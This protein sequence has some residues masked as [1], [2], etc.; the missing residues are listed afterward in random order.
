MYIIIVEN[1]ILLT[2][3]R[4][5]IMIIRLMSIH[6]LIQS[7][8]IEFSLFIQ[9]IRTKVNT[10]QSG[11]I[12]VK[13]NY[14]FTFSCSVQ[15]QITRTEC[16]YTL[17]QYLCSLSKTVKPKVIEKLTE[18]S[19]FPEEENMFDMQSSGNTHPFMV[20]NRGK[21]NKNEI[22]NKELQRIL[23]VKSMPFCLKLEESACYVL[24]ICQRE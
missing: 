8:I 11:F 17:T 22:T 24:L 14:F 12:E 3:M 4:T 23:K 1:F 13:I 6:L 2:T 10:L 21:Q 7:H 9:Q 15:I 16:K 19:V 20:V 5:V 18:T